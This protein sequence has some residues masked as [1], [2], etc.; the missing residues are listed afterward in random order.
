MT[1]I[2][3]LVTPKS[4][5]VV[6]PPLLVN[7]RGESLEQ[8]Y[9]RVFNQV[10]KDN[11]EHLF[12]DAFHHLR[13]GERRAISSFFI[14]VSI[15]F[16]FFRDYFRSVASPNTQNPSNRANQLIESAAMANSE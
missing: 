4:P 14:R 12:L 16:A 15:Y 10:Y 6:S 5:S 13:V 2:F 7:S 11:Q 3:K 8:R 1:T 9:G